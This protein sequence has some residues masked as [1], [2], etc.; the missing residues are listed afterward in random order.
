MQVGGPHKTQRRDTTHV[1]V[2]GECEELTRILTLMP[3][4]QSP[5]FL[6]KMEKVLQV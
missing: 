1:P 6:R 4:A 5:D 3:A 2:R